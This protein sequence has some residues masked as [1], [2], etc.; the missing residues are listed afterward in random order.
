M[1]YLEKKTQ[2]ACY[3]LFLLKKQKGVGWYKM[4]APIRLIS[5]NKRVKINIMYWWPK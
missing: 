2:Y 4:S 1:M 5:L 3:G